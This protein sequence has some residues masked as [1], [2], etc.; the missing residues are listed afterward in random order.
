MTNQLG[1]IAYEACPDASPFKPKWELL[2]PHWRDYWNS[3]AQAVAKQC[4]QTL[5]VGDTHEPPLD[6]VLF[7]N[8][9]SNSNDMGA[10]PRLHC[11]LTLAAS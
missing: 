7:N 4:A 6:S 2:Q 1:K 8:S 10:L 9:N 5:V 11:S 3:I